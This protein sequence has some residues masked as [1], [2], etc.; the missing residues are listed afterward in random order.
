MSN[1]DTIKYH[2]NFLKNKV[3]NLTPSLSTNYLKLKYRMQNMHLKP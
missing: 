3:E 2:Y 1:R